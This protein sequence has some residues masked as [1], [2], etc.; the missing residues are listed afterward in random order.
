VL[1]PWTTTV[2]VAVGLKKKKTTVAMMVVNGP[3]TVERVLQR[4]RGWPG[5]WRPGDRCIF[6]Q[7]APLDS[8]K[9]TASGKFKS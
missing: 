6:L 5:A 4:E 1:D 2:V 7:T 3:R 9:H 8:K